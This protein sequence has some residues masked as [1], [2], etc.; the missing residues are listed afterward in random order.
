MSGDVEWFK[1]G[2]KLELH[3]DITGGSL[4]LVSTSKLV[5]VGDFVWNP[6]VVAGA[7]FK[8]GTS[9]AALTIN[10][11]TGALTAS[12]VSVAT[13]DHVE[14]RLEFTSAV[15]WPWDNRI[16][17][18]R[19]AFFDVPAGDSTFDFDDSTNTM[20]IPNLD[21]ALGWDGNSN[22]KLG[23]KIVATD[24]ASQDIV[25][26]S[27]LLPTSSETSTTI[28]IGDTGTPTHTSSFS[29]SNATGAFELEL[30]QRSSSGTTYSEERRIL[31]FTD[32]T[33]VAGYPA[34]FPSDQVKVRELKITGG[35]LK[36]GAPG[37]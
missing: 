4:T 23:V 21:L 1:I 11:S 19:A 6:V 26:Y 35:R 12:A 16:V 33:Q 24:N 20:P 8:N 36:L 9:V 13:G 25:A 18:R 3:V 2:P 7:I 27:R 28:A 22:L 15:S 31:R 14:V 37:Q 17:L 34:G 30:C 32:N 10:S 29:K 5:N